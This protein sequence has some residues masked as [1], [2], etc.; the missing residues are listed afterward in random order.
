MNTL[1][2]FTV[3]YARK[4]QGY[5]LEI[6]FKVNSEGGTFGDAK[7]S[8]EML[9]VDVL[10]LTKEQKVKITQQLQDANKQG[11]RKMANTEGAIE[12]ERVGT[13]IDNRGMV[14]FEPTDS[15]NSVQTQSQL[16]RMRL[17]QQAAQIYD[18]GSVE[19]PSS[20]V[21]PNPP[22]ARPSLSIKN[23]PFSASSHSLN[24]VKTFVV[25]SCGITCFNPV[26]ILLNEE[27]SPTL[28]KILDTLAD[29]NS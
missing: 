8:P 6:L 20:I 24:P 4:S 10:K 3:G 18:V 29:D 23:C 16:I 14:V 27:G 2:L 19:Y 9:D 26:S 15:F 12:G 22:T 25:I 7:V 17:A 21:N 1:G 11:M 28:L 13:G 5:L